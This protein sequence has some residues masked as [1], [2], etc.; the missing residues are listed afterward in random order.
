MLTGDWRLVSPLL[1]L[2]LYSTSHQV[3][4]NYSSLFFFFSFFFS[5]FKIPS[6]V[7]FSGGATLGSIAHPY[8]RT[9]ASL[10]SGYL[11]YMLVNEATKSLFIFYD[12][13]AIHRWR[14]HVADGPIH[15]IKNESDRSPL[16]DRR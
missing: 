1:F 7:R 5:P 8:K 9:V 13:A 11:A 14:K 6:P 15:S 10:T 16:A 2:L 3:I 12:R 4:Q